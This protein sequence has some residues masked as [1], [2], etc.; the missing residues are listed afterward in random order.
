MK[1][2]LFYLLSALPFISAAQSNFHKGYVVTNNNDTLKG[3]VNYRERSVS[4]SSVQFKSRPDSKAE[5]FTLK[6]SSAYTV[7]GLEKFR[8]FTVDISMSSGTITNLSIGADSSSTR[9]T[10]FLNVIQE[11]DNVTLYLYKDKVKNRFYIS[12]KDMAVP[13]ELVYER[14]LDPEEPTRIV[15]VGKYKGQLMDLIIKYKAGTI[16]D[17]EKIRRVKYDEADLTKIVALINKKEVIQ[18]TYSRTRFFA[19]TGLSISKTAYRGE[20]DLANAGAENKSSVSP[21]LTAGVD[22]FA[23]PAIGKLIYRVELSLVQSKND[24]S[25]TT[26]TQ[27]QAILT[28]TFDQYTA[29]I[30]PQLIYNVYNTNPLKIFL[31]AGFAMNISKYSN[32]RSSRYNS[33]R[34][35]TTVTEKQIALEA[36]NTA[37]PLRVGA[38]FNKRI[39]FSAIYTPVTSITNYNLFNIGVQRYTV[40]LNYLF[41]K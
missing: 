10:V 21:I 22:L 12:D 14:F 20:N 5:T 1:R 37:F 36:F 19:G 24:I 17:S 6:Q 34:N 18:S 16:A 33:F 25:T 27:A 26:S 2:F 28:H 23:N 40:G 9:D 8:R 4:P 35:E 39:E 32:N 29:M 30:V 31:G 11:G 15:T 7:D 41:G 13:L 3:Y 38:V